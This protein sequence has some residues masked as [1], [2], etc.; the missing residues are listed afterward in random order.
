MSETPEVIYLIPG[1][2]LHGEPAM[3]WCDDP[4]PDE[5]CD[6]RDAIG[7]VREDMHKTILNTQSKS[8]NKVIEKLQMRVVELEAQPM[9]VGVDFTHSY[10]LRKQAEAIEVLADYHDEDCG[11]IGCL[12]DPDL[13]EFAD[14]CVRELSTD[15]I[16]EYAERLHNEAQNYE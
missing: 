10:V 7:Y 1:E 16:R 14:D 4:A 2:D 5:H 3:V 15:D 11:Y 8:F 13:E 6:V 9:T 12:S